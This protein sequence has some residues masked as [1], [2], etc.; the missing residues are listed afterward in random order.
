MANCQSHAR[1]I[2]TCTTDGSSLAI[3]AMPVLALTADLTFS[4]G[5]LD[6]KDVEAGLCPASC[7]TSRGINKLRKGDTLPKAEDYLPFCSTVYDQ[8]SP[9]FI[10][11]AELALG[12]VSLAVQ[13]TRPSTNTQS[14]LKT[15]DPTLRGFNRDLRY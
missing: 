10:A 4:K 5:L 1:S 6:R 7:A 8:R 15:H 3:G 11:M 13:L 12:V 2:P 9:R 14:P